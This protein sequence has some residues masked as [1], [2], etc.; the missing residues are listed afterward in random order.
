VVFAS[1]A[2]IGWIADFV[3]KNTVFDRLGMP[4]GGPY[5]VIPRLLS[6]ETSLNEGAL[7]GIGQGNALIFA[8][9]SVVAAVFVVY[10]LFVKGEAR[11][12]LL[13]MALGSVMAGIFGNLYDRL[14]LPGM[15]W[16]YPPDRVGQPVY[17]VRDWI[18]AQYYPHFDFPVFNIADSMLVC[19]A[20]L[21]I[22]HALRPEKELST[23]VASSPSRAA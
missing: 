23:S 11:D 18:H 16:N 20:L 2:V 3:S 22:W 21:L 19:G 8:G 6:F 13:T 7:F 5:W 12:L 4:G 17:A 10:W 1:I 15:T 9:M 14:G